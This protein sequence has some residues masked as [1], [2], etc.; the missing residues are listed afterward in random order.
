MS[1]AATQAVPNRDQGIGYKS[2]RD[3]GR[4]NWVEVSQIQAADDWAHDF[5]EDK[6]A[7]HRSRRI[8]FTL[9][10][11]VLAFEAGVSWEKARGLFEI[12]ER[13]QAL[14]NDVRNSPRHSRRR[15]HN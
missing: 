14:E 2:T 5:L 6:R 10:D 9:T 13:T 7:S 3:L 4:I 8:S 11:L 1:A 15:R 12:R